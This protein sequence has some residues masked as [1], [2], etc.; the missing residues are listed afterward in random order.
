VVQNAALAANAPLAIAVS[1]RVGNRR[2]HRRAFASLVHHWAGWE[3]ARV[4]YGSIDRP[5]LL[6][7][8]DADWSRPEEREANARAIPAAE[9]VVVKQAGHFLSLDAPRAVIEAVTG[10]LDAVTE[11]C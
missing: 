7:Y 8:G 11:Q 9:Y 6:L 1:D 3:K 4:E 5:V 10:G 2:G